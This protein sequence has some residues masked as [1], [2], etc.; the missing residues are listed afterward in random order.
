MNTLPH[1]DSF[2]LDAAQ[3]W[4]MLGN[5]AAADEELAKLT[6][7]SRAQAEVLEFEWSVHAAAGSWA[8]AH[9]VAGQL[10][11][12]APHLPFGWIHRA[13]AARRM[14]GGGLPAAW[15][16]LRPAVDRFP[17]DFLVPYNLACYAAQM[18][19]LD[20]AWE[21]LQKS[22]AAA[23]GAG[24]IKC[25]ALADADLEPLWPKLAQ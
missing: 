1:P 8:R 23:G 12:T 4:L 3:G 21:W 18:G 14:A 13:Y 2:H 16:A 11:A 17:K 19:R 20:E 10:V 5:P 25:M 9:E 24:R 22:I 6:P 15:E 7:A